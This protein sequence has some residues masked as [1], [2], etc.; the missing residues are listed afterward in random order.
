MV[1]IMDGLARALLDGP[2]VNEEEQWVKW[3]QSTR[4][5]SFADPEAMRVVRVLT[6]PQHQG[7]IQWA[8]TMVAGPAVKL[9]Y[10]AN[11]FAWG[12]F[13]LFPFM[14]YPLCTCVHEGL[15]QYPWWLCALMAMTLSVPM[16]LEIKCLKYLLP[17]QVFLLAKKGKP[18]PSIFGFPLSLDWFMGIYLCI[19]L[20]GHM[21]FVTN[22]LFLAKVWKTD[23][24]AM[25]ACRP[26]DATLVFKHVFEESR[27]PFYLLATVPLSSVVLGGWGFMALQ[28]VH[29][30]INSVPL[31]HLN[32]K[33]F[34]NRF[35]WCK[36]VR[37]TDLF[38]FRMNDRS[39]T[40]ED[41]QRFITY[42]SGC[43]CFENTRTHHQEALFALSECGR[44]ASLKCLVWSCMNASIDRVGDENPTGLKAGTV[45]I[46]M[47]RTVRRF[48][49]YTLLETTIFMQ[50]QSTSMG[51]ARCVDQD[52]T[53]DKQLMFSM[54][55]SITS[56]WINFALT[57]ATVYGQFTAIGRS[58]TED[59]KADK[60]ATEQG[61]DLRYHTRFNEN[62]KDRGRFECR[63]RFIVL[64][65]IFI[66][67]LVYAMLKTYMNSTACSCGWNFALPLS[68]GCVE[69]S[70]HY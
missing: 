54:A 23:D 56:S 35:P 1:L 34:N 13:F 33:L 10:Y 52:H 19:S 41:G 28:L 30:L 7:F 36:L 68:S 5:V 8:Q 69:Q 55:L 32:F 14:A 22:S 16:A 38:D 2:Q 21:D 44:M 51:L 50:I 62:A 48:F 18:S 25:K 47:H 12:A 57:S 61:K 20:L 26:D 42:T 11:I 17:A 29:G 45:L 65:V 59:P 60:E 27:F 70:S 4:L 43:G 64:A 53:V 24:V 31:Q 49:V 39:K 9:A 40:V 63:A 67:C 3:L 6:W 66:M 58:E 15:A 37:T 46:E